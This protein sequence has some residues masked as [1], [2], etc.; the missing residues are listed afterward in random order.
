MIGERE[1]FAVIVIVVSIVI[2]VLFSYCCF[3]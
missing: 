2:V 1:G 3:I